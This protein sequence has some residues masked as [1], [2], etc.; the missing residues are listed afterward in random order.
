MNS[1]ERRHSIYPGVW[2]D[3]VR[4]RWRTRINRNGKRPWSKSFPF[5][6]AGELRAALAYRNK[7]NELKQQKD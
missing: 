3:P 2:H 1:V 6:D 7:M 5:T 4:N